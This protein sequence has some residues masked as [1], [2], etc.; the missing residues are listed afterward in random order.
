MPVSSA[1]TRYP[2]R[3]L[4]RPA[5]LVRLDRFD[6]RLPV[7]HRLVVE[8]EVE[9]RGRAELEQLDAVR[10]GCVGVR[11]VRPDE[12]ALAWFQHALAHMRLARDHVIEAVSVVA[13]P[14]QPITRREEHMHQ[15]E[16]VGTLA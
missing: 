6:D 2:C 13:V 4:G 7:S 14:R 11:R 3:A 8:L 10:A 12:E 5:L 1:L 15:A 9:L 16:A